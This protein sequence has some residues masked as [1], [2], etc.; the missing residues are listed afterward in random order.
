PDC[1]VT[2]TNEVYITLEALEADTAHEIAF[3]QILI[4][5]TDSVFYAGDT[6]SSLTLRINPGTSQTTFRFFYEDTEFDSLV[7]S[8]SRQTKMI[9][10][11]CGAFNY[12]Q[13]LAV[14]SSSF[15]EVIVKNPQLISG[16]TTNITIKL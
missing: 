14:V 7:V 15:H 4:P 10:P 12:F 1:I 13:D 6:T 9:S 5:G 8:Y 11:K 2:A 16:G 3:N